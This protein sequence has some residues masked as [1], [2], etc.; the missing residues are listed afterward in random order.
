MI[1]DLPPLTPLGG[2]ERTSAPWRR[3]HGEA[4][5]AAPDWQPTAERFRD[6]GP[7]G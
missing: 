3:G 1:G 7:T 4:P 2:A 5:S 6:P